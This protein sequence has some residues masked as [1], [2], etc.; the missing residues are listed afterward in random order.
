MSG[1]FKFSRGELKADNDPDEVL[2]WEPLAVNS[3]SD[4]DRVMYGE[5]SAL[6]SK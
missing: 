2:A 5:C 1:E 6:R 4:A 3:S